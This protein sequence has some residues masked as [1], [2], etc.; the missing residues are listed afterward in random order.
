MSSFSSFLSVPYLLKDSSLHFPHSAWHF[1]SQ[2]H[3]LLVMDSFLSPF[4]FHICH[5]LAGDSFA[6]LSAA[7][8]HIVFHP[9]ASNSNFLTALPGLITIFLKS[10]K[11]WHRLKAKALRWTFLNVNTPL[12][13][14]FPFWL[15]IAVSLTI[16]KRGVLKQ[17]CFVISRCSLGGLV[18][19]EWHSLG[20]LC[21]GR[22]MFLGCMRPEKKVTVWPQKI[23]V[24][25]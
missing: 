14:T 10:F 12:L 15:S 5:S 18:M 6:K 19:G 22:Q 11:P 4:H 24:P 3:R 21:D 23:R 8:S 17:P 7:T 1:L 16:W 13:V 2:T 9:P 20:L 25:D